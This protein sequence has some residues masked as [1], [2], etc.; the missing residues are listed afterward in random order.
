MENLKDAIRL[1]RRGSYL[2][3]LDLK[4]AYFLVPIHPDS[5]KFL[6]FSYNGQLYE[7]NCL[8]FG[9][10]AAPYVFTKLLKP[11]AHRFRSQG[12]LSVFYLDDILLMG[13]S[14]HQCQ[15]N[16]EVA[17]KILTSLGL[18]LNIPKCQ[19]SPKT[20]LK[21]LGFIID[22]EKFT[23]ELPDQKRRLIIDLVNKFLKTSSCRIRELAKFIGTL[24]SACQAVE[25]GP[26]YVKVLE[27]EK[28]KALRRVDKDYSRRMILSDKIKPDLLWW[29][30]VIPRCSRLIRNSLFSL[31]IF[32]DASLTGWGAFC[33]GEST[34]GWWS[35]AEKQLHINI[36]ELKAAL[37]GLKC[38]ASSLTSCQ[39]LLR[40][41]NTTAIATI[42]K[43]GSVQFNKL[44]TESRRL[45]QWCEERSL[46]V[47]AS[48]I[49]SK[50]NFEADAESRKLPTDTEWEL[51]SWAFSRI[52]NSF[53]PF[54]VDLFASYLNHKCENYAAWRRDPGAMVI[55]AFTISWSDIYFYAFP[56]FSVISRVLQKILDDEAEGVIVVPYWSTQCWFPLIQMM[57]TSDP[58]ESSPPENPYP[59]RDQIVRQAYMSRGTPEVAIPVVMAS[60]SSGTLKQSALA[61]L[62]DVS[63]GEDPL[64]QRFFKG[65][66]VLRPSQP[67]YDYTWNPKS[68]LLSIEKWPDNSELSLKQLSKKLITLLALTTAHRIQS[69]STIKID[70]IDTQNDI[71]HI[72]IPDRIKTSAR[73]R[74]NPLIELPVF[75]AQPSLCVVSTLRAYMD[76]TKMLRSSSD[77]F[78]S[79]RKPHEPAS[80]QTISNWLKEAL[81]ECNIDTK[82]FT[83]H[84]TRHASTSLA[85]LKGINIET[86]G[87]T[88]GWTAE[89]SVFARFYNRPILES[90]SFARAIIESAHD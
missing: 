87:K 60:I 46:W 59:G 49:Q 77:L 39:I 25:Y 19:L 26:V 13:Q 47:F 36:L 2:A 24:V 75:R 67:K 15:K 66:S 32:S 18:I 82:V 58:E 6:R 52:N 10:N 79:T 62:A 64:I 89:S 71:V 35:D 22:S 43:M 85:A 7:F 42:N 81:A 72:K 54:E 84:S 12:I 8:P 9:L 51:A 38:F 14:A 34:G 30:E 88:A 41:D 48:Y 74:P 68:V 44:N 27:R 53:G 57:K 37:L 45:W 69:L 65:L 1:L 23:I 73:I 17:C 33:E 61:F 55:D 70:N 83:A 76:R 16:L 5:K 28:L 40:I 21:F 90:E 4:D 20:S 11:V 56:P 31:E 80:K 63:L 86:I 78:I 50:E 3:T 29:L